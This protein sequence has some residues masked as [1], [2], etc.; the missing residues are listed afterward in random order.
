ML[1][2]CLPDWHKLRMIAAGVRRSRAATLSCDGCGLPTSVVC[3]A[4]G[5]LYGTFFARSPLEPDGC[6]LQSVLS[7]DCGPMMV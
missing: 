2:K 7:F 6:R 4:N 1:G 3:A 5:M